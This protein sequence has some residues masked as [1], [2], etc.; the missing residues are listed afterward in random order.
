MQEMYDQELPRPLQA[1]EI[2]R[3]TSDLWSARFFSCATDASHKD[4][5]NRLDCQ[6]IPGF[7]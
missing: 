4:Y 5:L 1:H 7:I 6:E 2:S 3:E